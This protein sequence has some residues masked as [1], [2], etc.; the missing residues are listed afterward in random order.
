MR[1]TIR[2]DGEFHYD[3]QHVQR[4]TRTQWREALLLNLDRIVIK[5]CKRQ[6][7]ATSIGCGVMEVTLKPCTLPEPA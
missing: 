3:E 1:T 2:I 7:V 5:G 4:V 6:L